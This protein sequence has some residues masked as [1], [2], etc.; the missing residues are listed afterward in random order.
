MDLYRTCIITHTQSEETKTSEE[1]GNRPHFESSKDAGDGFSIT[2]I[3]TV[4][5]YLAEISAFADLSIS[6]SNGIVVL[7]PNGARKVDDDLYRAV[8]IYL[9]MMPSVTVNDPR[10]SLHVETQKYCQKDSEECSE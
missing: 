9:K 2:I 7:L 5:V 10:T 3:E 8:D 1:N 4:D 6:K